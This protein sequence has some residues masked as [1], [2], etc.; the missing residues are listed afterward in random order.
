MEANKD[1]GQMLT[2]EVAEVI[3]RLQDLVSF[4]ESNSSMNH[5]IRAC[6]ARAAISSL[7]GYLNVEN[8]PKHWED[9]GRDVS[10]GTD[11]GEI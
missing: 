4:L 9:L 1:E 7:Q 8:P 3:K 11:L 6:W 5:S 10:I 2:A